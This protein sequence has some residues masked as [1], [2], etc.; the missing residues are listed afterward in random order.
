MASDLGV[1]IS[2]SAVVGGALSGLTSVGKAMDTLKTTTDNLRRHQTELGETL[3]RNK[4][5]LG[6]ASAKQLWQEYDK[7]GASIAKLEVRYS[8]LN[9][10][11]AQKAVNQQKW[12]GIKSSWAGALESGK[13]P[14]IFGQGAGLD[15]DAVPVGVSGYRDT[16]YGWGSVLTVPTSGDMSQLII[17]QGRAWVRYRN[18]GTWI[19][20]ELSGADWF[21]VRNRPGAIKSYAAD[22]VNQT[23]L[24]AAFAQA[25]PPGSIAYIAGTAVPAGWLKANGAAVSRAGYADLFAAIGTRYGAGNGTSTFNLPDLRGEFVRGWDDSRGVDAGRALGSSQRGTIAMPRDDAGV[26]N[27]FAFGSHVNLHGDTINIA[28]YGLDGNSAFYMISNR[29]SAAVSSINAAGIVT[30]PRNVAL[31]AIIKI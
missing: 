5:R 13:L 15:F 10:V 1:S 6:V 29:N 28:D 18:S 26:D 8:K 23:E 17:G 25:S 20:T 2:V 9:A 14:Y 12:E 24:A 19:T 11:R 31:L 16:P 4:E 21:S 22:A 30:R 3:T 7:I 27:I